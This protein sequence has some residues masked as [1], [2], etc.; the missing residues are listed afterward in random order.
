MTVR[1]ECALCSIRVLTYNSYHS[2]WC[3]YCVFVIFSAVIFFLWNLPHFFVWRFSYFESERKQRKK[4]KRNIYIIYKNNKRKK[5]N[6]DFIYKTFWI[7]HR[8]PIVK[9]FMTW[10]YLTYSFMIIFPS[11]YVYFFMELLFRV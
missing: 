7:K 5:L 8:Q 9:V 4:P 1:K 11:C 10:T 6:I 2:Q 3:W